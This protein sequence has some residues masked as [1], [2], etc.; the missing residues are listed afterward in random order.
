[1]R[2]FNSNQVLQLVLIAALIVNAVIHF[3]SPSYRYYRENID[4]I[5]EG[6]SKFETKVQAD[7]IP[8]I[9][10][11]ASNRVFVVSSN[12]VSVSSSSVSSPAGPS[13]VFDTNSVSRLFSLNF[14]WFVFEGRYGF[15]LDGCDY[16]EGDRIFGSLIRSVS[17]TMVVTDDYQ[18]VKPL[19]GKFS[20]N[21]SSTVSERVPFVPPAVSN[22]SI[23][24]PMQPDAYFPLRQLK[25]DY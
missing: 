15:E 12:S 5:K 11:A 2:R 7:F 13:V 24:V 16:F 3:T 6:V 14:R 8:A 1:M 21:S 17:P 25:G 23:R 10:S 19:I 9:L 22:S 20:L 18:F 4:Q